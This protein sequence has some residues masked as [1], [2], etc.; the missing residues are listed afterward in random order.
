MCTEGLHGLISKAAKIGV[1]K[2]VS[3][4]R[5]GPKLIHLFFADGSLIFCRATESECH[6]L[7]DILAKY[8]LASRQQ[9]NRA[10]TNLFFSKS[11]SEDMQT[12]IKNL[13]GVAVIK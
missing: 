5:N 8:E 9:I 1:L 2:G 3:L 6:A 13:L 7:L 11:T 10:K 4:C 12:T